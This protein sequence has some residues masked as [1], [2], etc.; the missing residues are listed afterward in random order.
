MSEV[1]SRYRR[2]L[3]AL[4]GLV[5]MDG[6]RAQAQVAAGRPLRIVVPFGAGGIADL[7]VRVVAEHLSATLAQPVVVE[8]RPGAGGIVAAEQVARAAP[9]GQTLLLMSNAN[10]VSVNL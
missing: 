5:L 10:A 9:D 3:I 1:L 6:A 8:N 4:G 2:G 7:T